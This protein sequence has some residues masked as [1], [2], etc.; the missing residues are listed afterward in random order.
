MN[1]KIEVGLGNA[2]AFLE[3]FQDDPQIIG[4]LFL[5]VD[6]LHATVRLLVAELERRDESSAEPEN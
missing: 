2:D 1:P 4:Y 5:A 6:E 3:H